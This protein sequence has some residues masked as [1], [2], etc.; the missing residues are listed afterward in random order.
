MSARADSEPEIATAD[1]KPAVA[2]S[3]PDKITAQYIEATT[4][5]LANNRTVRRRLPLWGRLH[6]DRQLPF[7]CVYR[8][9]PGRDDSGT[10]SLVLGEAA[11][12]QAPGDRALKK[13]VSALVQAVAVAGKSVF[14]AFLIIEIW[15]SA[16]TE[17][18]PADK[19][20]VL[21]PAF[22]IVTPRSKTASATVRA[23]DLALR[24]SR[25]RSQSPQVD[26]VAS[27]R[28]APP[29]LPPL[30]SPKEIESSGV[31]LLGLEIQ[32][33]YRDHHSDA[34]FPLVLRRVQRELSRALKQTFFR[35]TRSSTSH[36][37]PHYQALGRRS[38]VKAV[39]QVDAQLA[40]VSNT[41]DFLLGVTPV[42][43][44]AAWK[45]F[46]QDRFE[47][48]PEFIYRAIPVSP[49]LLKR[50]LFSVPIERVEDPVLA[51]IFR[52]KQ[53]ELDRQLSGLMDRETKRFIY[54]SFFYEGI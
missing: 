17:G 18:D 52:E 36:L 22:R 4:E 12:L 6:V 3:R 5:R 40:Q 29:D 53:I 51:E 10:D 35:F 47:K 32:P 15:S 24:A 41:Y 43:P 14:G 37:P 26:V 49:L 33:V 42:N 54:T 39:W 13:Q 1:E 38:L 27:L 30:L 31:V 34:P 7:L 21:N 9:P 50:R 44:Q 2:A 46:Q 8:R 28:V 45:E 19:A 20:G 48:A 23:L 16:S 25:I 11:Y